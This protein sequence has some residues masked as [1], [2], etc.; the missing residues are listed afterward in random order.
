VL[1]TLAAGLLSD[2]YPAPV[3]LAALGPSGDSLG[4]GILICQHS[5][6]ASLSS[7]CQRPFQCQLVV[8]STC[9]C[10]TWS[11]PF[12]CHAVTH[13]VLTVVDQ[14]FYWPEDFPL[15]SASAIACAAALFSGWVACFGVPGFITPDGK[16]EVTSSSWG[17]LCALLGV[18][19]YADHQLRSLVHQLSGTPPSLAEGD[20]SSSC[21][22]G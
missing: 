2:W 14:C 10:T 22:C 11:A 15:S 17:A 5:N 3:L 6:R 13:H 16:F 8:S 19:H 4:K 20:A 7:C 18:Q 21:C 12:R 1:P 9:T